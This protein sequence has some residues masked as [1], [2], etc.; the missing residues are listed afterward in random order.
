MSTFSLIV[1]GDD[2]F[3]LGGIQH[4]LFYKVAHVLAVEVREF[5]EVCKFLWSQPNSKLRLTFFSLSRHDVSKKDEMSIAGV[6]TPRQEL[7]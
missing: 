3:L 6:G 1:I 2:S 7:F 4:E 5:A